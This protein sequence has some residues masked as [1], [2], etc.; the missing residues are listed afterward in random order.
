[1]QDYNAIDIFQEYLK[2]NKYPQEVVNGVRYGLNNGDKSVSDWINQYNTGVG[3]NN[4][5]LKHKRKLK[6]HV[7]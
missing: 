2:K 3:R 4:I 6:P 7:G 1:M 5:S